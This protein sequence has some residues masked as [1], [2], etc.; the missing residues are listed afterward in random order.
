MPRPWE[1]FLVLDR[2][3]SWWNFLRVCITFIELHNRF[4][5]WISC[6]CLHVFV[7]FVGVL[8]VLM[9]YGAYST[10]RH[11]AVSRIFLRFLWFSLTSVVITFLYVYVCFNNSAFILI[12]S[13]LFS[14]LYLFIFIF[15]I[16]TFC[17][18]LQKST[19]RRE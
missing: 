14:F 17:T 1:S 19:P 4:L 7:S 9:M 6:I 16:C 8:D 2:H 13:A 12:F 5:G 15:Y 3:L 10:T 11:L 18:W